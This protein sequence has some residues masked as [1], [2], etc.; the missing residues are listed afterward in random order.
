MASLPGVRHRKK[1][2]SRATGQSQA[3]PSGMGRSPLME[4]FPSVTW[5]GCGRDMEGRVALKIVLITV[6]GT[7]D[8]ARL[9]EEAT[10]IRFAPLFPRCPLHGDC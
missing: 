7:E 4:R 10:R 1:H 6:C 8:D 2:L 5:I 3:S 9:R